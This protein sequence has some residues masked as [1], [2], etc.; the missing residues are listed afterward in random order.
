MRRADHIIAS[1][2]YEDRMPALQAKWGAK[3]N[4]EHDENV[5]GHPHGRELAIRKIASMDPT[6]NK[7]YTDRLL[8]WYHQ[9][10]FRLEDHPAVSD[11]LRRFHQVKG[12]ME[13]AHRDVNRHA[14]L[15]DLRDR[16]EPF[17]DV[18]TKSQADAAEKRDIERGSTVIHDSPTLQVREI[19]NK[20]AACGLG[21]GTS[22]C[23]AVRNEH[24]MFDRYR[25]HGQL[26]SIHDKE[27]GRK[28]QVHFNAGQLM[29][30]QDRPV[31][32]RDLAKKHPALIDLFHGRHA[33]IFSDQKRLER[34]ALETPAR[35]SDTDLGTPEEV[36]ADRFRA[37]NLKPGERHPRLIAARD[38]YDSYNNT[39]TVKHVRAVV[40]GSEHTSPDTIRKLFQQGHDALA[41]HAT[42]K[43]DPSREWVGHALQAHI[44][45]EHH[46][47][48]YRRQFSV[49][50][51]DRNSYPDT[52][53]D[54]LMQMVSSPH[55]HGSAAI[56]AMYHPNAD[57]DVL[58]AAA[59]NPHRP[60][61]RQQVAK[62][63]DA[64][65]D[66]VE[67]LHTDPDPEVRATA[68]NHKLSTPEMHLKAIQS[69]HDPE[70]VTAV[71][72][73]AVSPP[74]KALPET[75]DHIV[76][77]AVQYQHPKHRMVRNGLFT[78]LSAKQLPEATQ[79]WFLTTG[80][81]KLR[82]HKLQG[83]D[84]AMQK[85]M[86]HRFAD[87]ALRHL[88]IN[89]GAHPDVVQHIAR[90]HLNKRAGREALFHERVPTSV[91]TEI[92]KDMKRP[93]AHRH[94]AMDRLVFDRDHGAHLSGGYGYASYLAANE[95]E[96][97]DDVRHW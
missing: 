70:M 75:L 72:N 36:Q 29:D 6:G 71:A 50:R 1:V 81:R 57:H 14:S 27:N 69:A 3:L 18:Q 65:L 33:D 94:L 97:P 88:A 80:Y 37:T 55:V 16:L 12:R 34:D 23:T 51:G 86:Q 48:V 49:G 13:P 78:A 38:A 77:K 60:A 25:K 20:E 67:K 41:Q 43:H 96:D 74:Y 54:V 35:P 52:P 66:V 90:K 79:R 61:L 40:A 32:S 45:A 92:A 8:H 68:M 26:Y 87:G 2:L 30:E 7:Q 82:G 73:A 59:S 42:Q 44:N 46:A 9:G 21:V 95:L 93:K 11:T 64:P 39:H 83:E 10:Q 28:Y 53:K 58:R 5:R 24:N 85:R 4:T 91:A 19:H 47:M 84:P 76:R 17:R 63:Q 62:R 31:S 15:H 56:G 22:W 89:D